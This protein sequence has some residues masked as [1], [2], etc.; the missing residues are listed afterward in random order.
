MKDTVRVRF[1]PSPTGPLHI[2]G[3]RTTLFNYIFARQNDGVFVLRI[4]DT[5]LARNDVKF[6]ENIFES[7]KWLGFNWDE[8]YRQSERLDLYKEYM[9]KLTA[10]GLTYEEDGAVFFKLPEESRPI[11]VE[12]IIR[13]SVEFQSRDF[14]DLVI[15]KKDGMPT[16]HFANVV[17]DIDLNITH[18]IRGEEHLSN[19]PRHLLLYEALGVPTPKFAHIPLI[20]NE[21]RS[22]MSK[23]SGDTAVSEYIAAGYLPEAL[24][25]FLVQLGWADK[26]GQEFLTFDDI[27][28][29]FDLT[30]VQKG[31]AVFNIKHLNHLNHHYL[32]QKSLDDYVA[33][34]A[35]FIKNEWKGNESLLRSALK[36][37]QDRAQALNEIPELI[38]FFFGD[39]EYP[40]EMLVFKKSD[41]AATLKGLTAAHSALSGVGGAD[42]NQEN[43]QK[44]L[45][46][47]RS[48]ENLQPGDIFW[49]VRVALSGREASPSPVELLE[50]LGADV[51]LGRIQVA[52]DKLAS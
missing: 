10:M 35:P 39:I 47:V 37:I 9:A 52:L 2:G 16:Y 43:L 29:K 41:K 28:S 42:W 48:A 24:T 32:M 31:G 19:T 36:L 15:F 1:A 49:P 21:D 40:A 14:K 4:D 17:D 5:D 23:R 44:V 38:E 13:G 25:N 12:D 7:L 30:R 51:S 34:A 6:E 18:V 46:E 27:M 22:K 8:Q 26:E 11:I 50:A 33:L 3:A 45:D 20:L